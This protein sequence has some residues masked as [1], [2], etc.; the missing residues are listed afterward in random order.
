MQDHN[1]LKLAILRALASED[2]AT[3]NNVFSCLVDAENALRV[4]TSY[5]DIA[6]AHHTA[7]RRLDRAAQHLW[8]TNPPFPVRVDENWHYTVTP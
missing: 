4:L 7:R 8:G 3:I 1:A 5:A 2:D 6:D